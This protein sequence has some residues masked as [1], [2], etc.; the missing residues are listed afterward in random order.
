MGARKVLSIYPIRTNPNTGKRKCPHISVVSRSYG[1]CNAAAAYSI[2][3]ADCAVLV[4]VVLKTSRSR[5]VRAAAQ[6]NQKMRMRMMM[7]QTFF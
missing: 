7:M 5:W 3:L 1:I 6:I 4:V 2:V